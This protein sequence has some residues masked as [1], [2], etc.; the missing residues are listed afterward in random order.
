MHLSVKDRGREEGGLR[1]EVTGTFSD[2][3]KKLLERLNQA[4]RWGYLK[5]K[6]MLSDL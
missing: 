2:W 5:V 6:C 1:N 4:E 3:A